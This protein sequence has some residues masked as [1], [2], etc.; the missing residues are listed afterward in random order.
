MVKAFLPS[1]SGLTNTNMRPGTNRNLRPALLLI[2]ALLPLAVTGC[3]PAW[4]TMHVELPAGDSPESTFQALK[5]AS[6]DHDWPKFFGCLTPEA[7]HDA[8]ETM[9]MD[10]GYLRFYGDLD[11]ER[12]II[13]PDQERPLYDWEKERATKVQA[14]YEAFTITKP[15]ELK[16][17]DIGNL[18][19][20]LP[21]LYDA[22]LPG[23]VQLV[24]DY[25]TMSD[26][27]IEGDWAFAKVDNFPDRY[28]REGWGNL[29]FKKVDGKWL[30][31]ASPWWMPWGPPKSEARRDEPW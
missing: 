6:A 27:Q 3:T 20:L 13:G 4:E 11:E 18:D 17:E 29:H 28:H 1:I 26:I 9:L 2:A 10:T 24:T 23:G 19:E 14:V 22:A 15:G 30:V 7:R 31:D 12:I 16:P 5:Q 8:I 21:A 25:S